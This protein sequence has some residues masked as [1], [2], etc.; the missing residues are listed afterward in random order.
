MIKLKNKI[1]E[2]EKSAN[3]SQITIKQYEKEIEDK[4]E[5]LTHFNDIEK[6]YN[7]IQKEYKN[8]EN[9]Y[10]DVYI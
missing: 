5:K 10:Q 6:K 7:S 2:L 4:D 8:L 3:D 1:I 9:D